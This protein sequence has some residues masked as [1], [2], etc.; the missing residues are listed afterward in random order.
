M[1]D[2]FEVLAYDTVVALGGRVV[3][4]IGDEVMFTVDD[5]GRAVDIALSLAEAYHDDES[6]SD[7][8]VSVAVGPVLEREGDLFG[9]T[10][11]L[12]SRIVSIAFEGSVVVSEEV[13]DALGRTTRLV[14]EAAARPPAQGHRPGAAV[15]RAPGGRLLRGRERARAGPPPPGQG[16]RAHRRLR[17][18]RVQ[19][20]D[21]EE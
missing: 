14:L 21:R 16:A 6:L 2:R 17:R 1:V 5:V 20:G 11:N 9:P 15:G 13:H 18:P 7:V 12:A 3:K 4:M 10:V 8:R 19:D